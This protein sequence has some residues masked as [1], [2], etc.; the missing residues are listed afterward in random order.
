MEFLGE[1]EVSNSPIRSLYQLN[2]TVKELVLSLTK[3]EP[4]GVRKGGIA[5]ITTN[6]LN[7]SDIQAIRITELGR[8]TLFVLFCYPLDLMVPHATLSPGELLVTNPPDLIR[9][10]LDEVRAPSCSVTVGRSRSASTGVLSRAGQGGVRITWIATPARAASEDAPTN[11][12]AAAP[13]TNRA[14]Q[15]RKLKRDKS[16]KNLQNKLHTIVFEYETASAAQQNSPTNTFEGPLNSLR[17]DIWALVD[18]RTVPLDDQ[19][20]K[21]L[22]AA[23]KTSRKAFFEA[24]LEVPGSKFIETIRSQPAL[25]RLCELPLQER[26]PEHAPETPVPS[27]RLPA[28]E[29]VKV[30]LTFGRKATVGW[31]SNE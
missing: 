17:D 12:V 5:G 4:S 18:K 20:M 26:Q 7:A 10:L 3:E 24:A 29:T 21:E 2:V 23:Y 28:A 16:T 11:A 25:E 14:E 30:E 31:I 19:R 6:R 13:L 8:G 9:D 15:L 22:Q 27:R 1:S